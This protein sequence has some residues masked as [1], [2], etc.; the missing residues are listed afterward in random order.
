MVLIISLFICY[1]P[2][3]SNYH[4]MTICW[5]TIQLMFCAVMCWHF[6]IAYHPIIPIVIIIQHRGHHRNVPLSSFYQFYR[7]YL[8]NL[9]HMSTRGKD[10]TMQNNNIS[11][12]THVVPF[13]G[14][15]CPLLFLLLFQ[16]NCIYTYA[17][18]S[19][20]R[21]QIFNVCNNNERQFSYLKK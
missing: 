20:H 10:E 11:Q 18:F 19:M 9:S 7:F 5:W 16:K 12:P 6:S 3:H 21:G 8:H 15:L 1:F 2:F 13:S 14:F 17:I 4:F